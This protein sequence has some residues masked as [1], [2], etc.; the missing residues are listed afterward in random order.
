MKRTSERTGRVATS[1]AGMCVRFKSSTI[2][3]DPV[4]GDA[5]GGGVALEDT[6]GAGSSAAVPAATA[7]FML[8]AG[9]GSDTGSAKNDAMRVVKVTSSEGTIKLNAGISAAQNI[10]AESTQ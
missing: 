5:A 6:I 7:P 3:R 1:M 9:I 2:V 10:A 4:A 8:M